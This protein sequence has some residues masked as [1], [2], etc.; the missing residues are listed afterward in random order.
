MMR[1]LA[2]LAHRMATE[3]HRCLS[4][5]RQALLTPRLIRQVLILHV[6]VLVL[7][8]VFRDADDFSDWELIPFLNANSFAS[9]WQL[10][11]R[12]EVH[13]RNPFSFSMNVGAESVLSAV[14]LR[15]LGHF[16]LYW[17]NVFVLLFYDALFFALVY[18]LFSV[19][20]ANA[21][22]ECV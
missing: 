2:R 6:I 20:F 1:V 18:G 5:Q 8:R 21:F 11:Q 3:P 7:V 22:A 16:S 17:S 13:F 19:V 15:G 4:S 12:P 9:L 14:L 10:L